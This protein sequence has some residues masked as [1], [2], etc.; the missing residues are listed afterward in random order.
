MPRA[1][2]FSRYGGA[3]VLELSDIEVGHPGAGQALVAV[4]AAGVQPSDAATRRGDFA[5]WNPV[6]FHC[7]LGKEFAGVIEEVGEGVDAD[8]VGTAV[9][10]FQ[11]LACLAEALVVGIDQFVPKPDGMPWADAGALSA[12][13]QTADTALDTLGV[14][15]GDT[16][17][18][19]AAA[20]GVG[21]FAVQL[22]QVRG[23]S[24]IGAASPANH[25]YLRDLGAIPVAYGPGLEDRVREVA[26]EGVS[27]S[28]DAIGGEALEI[29]TGLVSDRSRIGTLTDWGNG[30]RLG[31]QVIGPQ[32]SAERL[33][34]LVELYER[35]QLGVS[36]WKTLPLDQ[37][38]A[39]L[40]AVE[41]GHVRG[42]VVVTV[43]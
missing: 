18:I 21:S 32:R 11:P 6:S 35:R 33:G 20:G 24:V 43:G 22:A 29:S 3:D 1:I 17:L 41:T 14:Y 2:T 10:G 25:Q 27:A 15:E 12:S 37:T 36:I 30:A 9:V 31:I 23:A 40:T 28:L 39:A 5:A 26:R 13:G 38:A 8:R 16:V 7:Q 4:R 42:K 19:H 34:R